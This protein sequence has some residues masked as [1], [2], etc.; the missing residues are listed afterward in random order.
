MG[1]FFLMLF[2]AIGLFGTTYLVG[3]LEID[4]S[5]NLPWWGLGVGVAFSFALSTV[6]RRRKKSALKKC[7]RR[8]GYTYDFIEAGSWGNCYAVDVDKR[9]LVLRLGMDTMDYSWADIIQAEYKVDPGPFGMTASSLT[10]TMKD[11][12]RPQVRLNCWGLE[13]KEKFAR[14]QAAGMIS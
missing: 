4:H 3:L 10:L 12:K 1:C 6:V 13:A 8:N 11:I 14:L 5:T 7:A 9:H 2:G